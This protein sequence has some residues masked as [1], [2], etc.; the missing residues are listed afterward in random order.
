LSISVN[1][2]KTTAQKLEMRGNPVTLDTMSEVV[3]E[4]VREFETRAPKME[5][6][7]SNFFKKIAHLVQRIL[8][9]TVPLLGKIIGSLFSAIGTILFIALLISLIVSIINGP[10]YFFDPEFISLI[11][12]P[13]FFL[14]LGIIFLLTA[15]PA[16]ALIM[17][18]SSLLGTLPKSSRA[19]GILLGLWILALVAAGTFA[20]T[21]GARMHGYIEAAYRN[22]SYEHT[23][24]RTLTPFTK[25]VV[26]NKGLVTVTEGAES[27]IIL[28]GTEKAVNEIEVINEN[29]TLSIKRTRKDPCI[30]CFRNRV[31]VEIITPSL[32]EVI[33]RNGSSI[34]LTNTKTAALA[35][36][37][38]TGSSIE[39]SGIF[40]TLIITAK[41][42]SHVRADGTVNSLALTVKNGSHVDTEALV[43]KEGQVE[44]GNGSHGTIQVSETLSGT[45][46]NGS[47]LTQFGTA[48]TETIKTDSSSHLE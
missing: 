20:A 8:G 45:L 38:E 33:A 24:E 21:V 28:R 14:A 44:I 26:E 19:F 40:E 5:S 16:L 27:A 23:E 25:L 42:G 41:N 48:E 46:H 47:H 22:A 6:A 35:I 7:A 29:G 18:G 32:S 30:F 36:S 4:K 2:A 12:L 11:S 10:L 39:V 1:E 43:A 15:L 37:A 34:T 13:V 17:V 31:A 3:K 9:G